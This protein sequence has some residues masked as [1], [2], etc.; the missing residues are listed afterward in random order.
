MN[1]PVLRAEFELDSDKKPKVART[2]KLPHY[3]IKLMVDDAPKDTYAVTY[4]L[5]RTYYDP[6]RESRD[7]SGGFAELVTSYG[8]YV[9]TANVRTKSGSTVISVPLSSALE[10]SYGGEMPDLVRTAIAQ[11]KEH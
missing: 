6:I 9:V 7:R 11:I 4:K 5:D 3:T 1:E 2:G 8:D 10:K